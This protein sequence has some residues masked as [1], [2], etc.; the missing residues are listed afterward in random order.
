MAYES[1]KGKARRSKVDVDELLQKLRLGGA[2]R[3]GVVL[4]KDD[5]VMETDLEA[6][7]FNAG[8]GSLEECRQVQ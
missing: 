6:V 3:D 8:A 7:K 1:V 5:R 2:E 4:A